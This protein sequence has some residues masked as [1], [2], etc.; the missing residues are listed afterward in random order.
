[1]WRFWFVRGHLTEGRTW[2]ERALDRRPVEPTAPLARALSG[3]TTLAAAADDLMTAQALA[4]ERLQVCRELGGDAAIASALSGLANVTVMLGGRE[5][6]ARLYEEAAVRARAAGADPALASI[7]SNL[8][9]VMLLDGDTTAGE[10]RCREAARLFEEL[11]FHAD[12]A[13]AWLNVAIAVVADARAREALPV[14][15]GSLRTYA[16][17]QHADGISY[18]LDAY[19][20]AAVQLGEPRRAAVLMG[21]ARTIRRG[22]GGTPEPLERALRDRT[23][24]G[25][26]QALGVAAFDAAR[27]EGEQ[28]ATEAAVELALAAT[29]PRDPQPPHPT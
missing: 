20:A 23:K 19:A 10:R 25:V 1:M 2:L 8:G 16:R 15:A 27:T 7:M 29:P 13:G 21:A 22:T 12:A 28:L 18:C 24:V 5:H 11:G 6:A 17:L 3:A 26:A 14:L 9:Y 4:A